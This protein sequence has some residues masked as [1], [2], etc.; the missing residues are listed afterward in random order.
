MSNIPRL[1]HGCGP[2]ALLHSCPI[3]IVL[4]GN[5][6]ELPSS[7]FQQRLQLVM[8][9]AGVPSQLICSGR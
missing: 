8:P 2:R 7:H 1:D 3:A 5:E 9:L 6:F 4:A